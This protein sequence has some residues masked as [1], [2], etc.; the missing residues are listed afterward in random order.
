M[1]QRTLRL[2]RKLCFS[3]SSA[4]ASAQVIA[5]IRAGQYSLAGAEEDDGAAPVAKP[6]VA[7]LV[8]E[9][10][11]SVAGWAVALRFDIPRATVLVLGLG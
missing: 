4:P 3:L 2:A 8:A 11:W 1:K 6:H 10:P 9:A 7:L 5:K